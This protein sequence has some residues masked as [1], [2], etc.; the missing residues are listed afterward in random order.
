MGAYNLRINLSTFKYFDADDSSKNLNITIM[1]LKFDSPLSYFTLYFATIAKLKSIINIYNEEDKTIT[2]DKKELFSYSD[3]E[4][5]LLFV[6]GYVPEND[7]AY[8][9]KNRVLGDPFWCRSVSEYLSHDYFII[10]Y[11]G[12][13]KLL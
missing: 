13:Y 1:Y 6:N 8:Q 3:R 7:K 4:E 5:L 11:K 12:E 10:D 2:A 9:K